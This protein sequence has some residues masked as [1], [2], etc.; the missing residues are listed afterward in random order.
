MRMSALTL[1]LTAS[2][3]HASPVSLLRG[4]S[5][6]WRGGPLVVEVPLHR[7]HAGAMRDAIGWWRDVTGRAIVVEGV[8]ADL[9][10]YVPCIDTRDEIHMHTNYRVRERAI[11]AAVIRYNSHEI[12]W[13]LAE[14]GMLSPESLRQLMSSLF[15]HEI[16]HALGLGH[17][18]DYKNVMRP[19]LW[20]GNV[21]LNASQKFFLGAT[22]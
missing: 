4:V 17:C 14:V 7:V 20:L 3:A 15:A 10:L 18:D 11:V 1:I 8:A 9:G 13:A 19:R 2:C 5:E 22:N 21:E 6:P 16:G 12:G